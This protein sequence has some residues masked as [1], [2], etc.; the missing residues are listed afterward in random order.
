MSKLTDTQ[1]VLLSSASRR[2]DGLVVISAHARAGAAK[3]VKPMLDG[4]LLQEIK[5]SADMSAVEIVAAT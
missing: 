2:D 5:A 4:D 1:L 3:V